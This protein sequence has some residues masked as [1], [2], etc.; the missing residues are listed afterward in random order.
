MPNDTNND[1]E[2]VYGLK[3]PI[4]FAPINVIYHYGAHLDPLPTN[5]KKSKA[6]RKADEIL[7]SAIMLLGIQIAESEEYWM[8]AVSDAEQS[9]DVRTGKWIPVANN[10]APDFQMQDIEV[11]S[12][13]PEKNET[14]GTF[15]KRTKLSGQ[16]SYDAKT[17][18]LCHMLTGA[19]TPTKEIVEE[20]GE[21]GAVC[22]VLV[23]GRTHPTEKKYAL[24]QVFPQYKIIAAY[25]VI[26]TL[27]KRTHTGVLNLRRGS[28]RNIEH[29]PEEKQC[30][31][32]S[33]GFECP[34]IET[35]KTID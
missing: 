21:T 27:N 16:R 15:L 34:I 13:V 7:V 6:F 22:P 14:L 17:T 23:L 9:P 25:D 11:V 35:T 31:F 26:Q 3:D 18:I 24:L 20:L 33:V 10:R 28:K 29:R 8:Q 30:P 32:H 5:Q 4:W 12:F 19:P 1:S 2:K